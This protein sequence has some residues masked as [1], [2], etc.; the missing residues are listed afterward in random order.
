MIGGAICSP[1]GPGVS[2]DLPG[3]ESSSCLRQPL[4]RELD[5]SPGLPEVPERSHAHLCCPSPS[6]V[7][8]PLLWFSAPSPH[9]AL[10]LAWLSG[11]LPARAQCSG[12]PD[13]ALSAFPGGG[14][15][16]AL[17]Y[18]QSSRRGQSACGLALSGSPLDCKEHK[19]GSPCEGP[20]CAH[21][22]QKQSPHLQLL[23]LPAPTVT[24]SSWL[25]GPFPRPVARSAALSVFDQEIG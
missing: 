7:P 2:G 4:G 3:L 24:L 5:V 18:R 20:T 11:S 21:L 16:R 6:P 1:M 10:L 23:S 19:L 22:A 14:V 15:R 25:P 8:F 9:R 13:T 12:S 17:P